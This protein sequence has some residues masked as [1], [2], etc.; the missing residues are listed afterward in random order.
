MS[1]SCGTSRHDAACIET[2]HIDGAVTEV[3]SPMAI[4]G[5]RELP[6]SGLDFG[7]VMSSGPVPSVRGL[8]ELL[9]WG[10]TERR[11]AAPVV[12]VA[13]GHDGREA[14]THRVPGRRAAHT[15]MMVTRGGGSRRNR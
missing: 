3:E 1:K 6:I 13:N 9:C 4:V 11:C 10:R 2:R 7:T 14:V 15:D 8:P 12:L 5:Y